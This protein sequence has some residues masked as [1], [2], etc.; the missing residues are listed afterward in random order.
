MNESTDAVPFY[1]EG[2]RFSCRR[3]SAC[4]RHE[5]GYVFLSDVDTKYLAKTLK[6]GYT[7]FVQRYCRWVL[8]PGG[9]KQLSLKE[10]ANYDCVFWDGGCTVYES[11]PLQCKTFPFWESTVYSSAAWNNIDCPGI[12]QGTLYGKD[13]IESCLARRKAEPVLLRGVS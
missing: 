5:P 12:N 4:C 13:Y 7:L 6:M 8:S 11:R 1:A 9:D 10:K 2:L 3:C